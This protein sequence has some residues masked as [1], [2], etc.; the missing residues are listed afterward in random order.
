MVAVNWMGLWPIL[1]QR[2]KVLE[3]LV[4]QKTYKIKLNVGKLEGKK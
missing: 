2:I 4:F 1:K 3:K